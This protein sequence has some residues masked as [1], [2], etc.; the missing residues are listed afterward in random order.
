MSNTVVIGWV[1]GIIGNFVV[2]WMA[3]SLAAKRENK[4]DTKRQWESRIED[5]LQI[6]D[7]VTR[8]ALLYYSG[9]KYPERSAQATIIKYL[10]QKIEGEAQDIGHSTDLELQQEIENVFEVI[11]NGDFESEKVK[12]DSGRC[13]RISS[14]SEA[15]RRKAKKHHT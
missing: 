5:M 11:T 10:L 8:M 7:E 9:D 14:A 13:D 4:K 12:P 3:G 2:A 15:V 6:L 1:A